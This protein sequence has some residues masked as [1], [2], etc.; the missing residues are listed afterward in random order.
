MRIKCYA[1]NKV[2]VLAVAVV[3]AK[4]Y[5]FSGS[6]ELALFRPDHFFC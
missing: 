1:S 2:E 6:I 5:Y 3:L 4:L